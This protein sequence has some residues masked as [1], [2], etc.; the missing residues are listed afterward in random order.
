MSEA[1]QPDS[2]SHSS[3]ALRQLHGREFNASNKLYMLPADAPEQDRLDIQ[4][5]ALRLYRQSL[6]PNPYLVKA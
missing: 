2:Y 3:T 1:L 4:H 5:E 6:Y